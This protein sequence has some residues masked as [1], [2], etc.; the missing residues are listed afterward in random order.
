MCEDELLEGFNLVLQVH[1]VGNGFVSV[2]QSKQHCE[3][4]IRR[5]HYL[6]FVWVVDRPQTNILFVFESAWLDISKECWHA[7]D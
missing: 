5:L 3:L 1:Q 4:V 7:T 6:P 2:L